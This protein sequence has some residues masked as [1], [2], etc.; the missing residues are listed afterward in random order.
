MD[1]TAN[2]KNSPNIAIT[3]LFWVGANIFSIFGGV[4]LGKFIYGLLYPFFYPYQFPAGLELLILVDDPVRR[5][6]IIGLSI[7]ILTGIL[8]KPVLQ[9]YKLRVNGWIPLNILGWGV[10]FAVAESLK[11]F[12][13]QLGVPQLLGGAI[14]GFSQWFVLRRQFSKS[15]WWIVACIIGSF[16]ILSWIPIGYTFLNV[17]E[18][19]PIPIIIAGL[20]MGIITGITLLWLQEN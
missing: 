19:Y 5:M 12:V 4:L 8:E 3:S 14:I 15:Y 9:R 13:G 7:G 17:L 6:V 1:A 16:A 18:E 11:M 20:I 10:G 2:T